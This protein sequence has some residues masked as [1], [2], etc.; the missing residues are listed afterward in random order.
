MLDMEKEKKP[1]RPMKMPKIFERAAKF[2]N[3]A[4]Q[5]GGLEIADSAIRYVAVAEGGL[6]TFSLKL[7]PGIIA[8]GELKDRALFIGALRD[9]RRQIGVKPHRT[10]HV[11]VVL[12]PG[13]VFSQ[14]FTIPIVAK[15]K[16]DESARLNLQ[17][18]SPV[19]ADNAYYDY[20]LLGESA[21]KSGEYELLGAFIRKPIVDG[22]LGA[23]EEAAFE[24]VAMEFPA[25]ALARMIVE[26][27][28]L[29]IEKPHFILSVTND[30]LQSLIIRNGRVY[31]SHFTYW[32]TVESEGGLAGFL[33]K[34]VRRVINFF[35]NQCQC[36]IADAAVVGQALTPEVEKIF[37]ENFSSIELRQVALKHYPQ[38]QPIWFAGLGAAYR[39]AVPRYKDQALTLTPIGSAAKYF[40]TLLMN[41]L[42]LWRNIIAA[43]LTIALVAF[44]S[45]DG[46]LIRFSRS[47]EGQA[48]ALPA[49]ENV[50]ASALLARAEEFNKLIE[51]VGKIRAENM[52]LTPYLAQIQALAA[53]HSVNL[54]RTSL[55]RQ[56]DA[57]IFGEAAN[58]SLI[59]GFKQALE[60]DPSFQNIDLPL[61]AIKVGSDGSFTFSLSFKVKALVPE[62]G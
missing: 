28:A 36:V 60:A 33:N 42:W 51:I 8:E 31:L 30:G 25:L 13:G 17:M 62:N 56:G 43:A 41:F 32:L 50:E 6:K 55:N 59:I 44:I 40:K 3:P 23:L 39:G 58:E 49:T 12:P 52:P 57:V 14:I 1:R 7:P 2:L 35:M 34:E 19:E 26:E 38:L 20:E 45:G 24:P 37:K 27:Q 46:M 5:V 10:A 47:L 53:A 22:L 29:N 48:T 18:I 54:I 16:M 61:T 15:N 9:L 21:A 11:V 4:P